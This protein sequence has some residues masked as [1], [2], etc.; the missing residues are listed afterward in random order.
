MLTWEIL[1]ETSPYLEKFMMQVMQV[2]PKH[3]IKLYYSTAF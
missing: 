3:K 2:E 1:L